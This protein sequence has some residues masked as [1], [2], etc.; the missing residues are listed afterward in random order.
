MPRKALERG[1]ISC[2]KCGG[3]T[4]IIKSISNAERSTILRRRE[5]VSGVECIHR[6]T[7]LEEEYIPKHNGL[8]KTG[9]DGLKK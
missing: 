4:K 1:G 6:F 3:D 2:P 5:C 7:T 9:L 8:A